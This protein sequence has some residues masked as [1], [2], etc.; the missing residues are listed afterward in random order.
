[1]FD[2]DEIRTVATKHG[3]VVGK[4]DLLF[5]TVTVHQ[6]IPERYLDLDFHNDM[7][8]LTVTLS[9]AMQEQSRAVESSAESA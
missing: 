6:L 9:A 1:M 5:V 4:D 7:M 8:P 2:I 3:V